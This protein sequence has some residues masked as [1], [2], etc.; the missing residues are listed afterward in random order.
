MS[1]HSGATV[2]PFRALHFDPRRVSFDAVIAPPF[3]IISPEQRAVLAARSP[4]NVVH[5]ILPDEGREQD[6]HRLI[7]RWRSDGVL[8]LDD[9]PC[10]YWVEQEYVDPEGVPRTRT[11][12][13]GLARLEPYDRRIV[14]PHERTRADPIANR[15]ELMRATRAQLS[16]IFAVYHDPQRR[17]EHALL[18]HR[19]DRAEI[20]VIDDD[21]TRHRLWRVAAGHEVVADA[22][23][24][25]TLLIADGHHRYET[26]LRYR[27]ETGAEGDAAAAWV[28]V[29]MANADDG[30]TIYPTHRLIA[31]VDAREEEA[32]PERLAAAGLEVRE[33]ADGAAA[34]ADGPV[35]AAFVVLR[36]GRAPLLAIG[37]APGVDADLVQETLLSA[38]LGLDPE[39]VA[40]TDRIA[41]VHR[42]DEAI[43][44]VTP[45]TIGVLVRAP[46]IAQVECSALAG[47]TMP[48]KSTYFFPKT[49][50]GFV[51]YTLDDC[52]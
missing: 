47:R 16:P 44:G 45:G 31:G 26:A 27:A 17:A 7:C 46:T 8:T 35:E 18:E 38:V 34:L 12:F 25:S 32:L 21:G 33:C 19:D 30:L 2:R 41:Y 40:A 22:L 1:D 6:V 15:L 9:A 14:L 37:T 20:D 51:F 49:I 42:A 48:Q 11:G 36:A 13:I 24:R 5:L 29:Y 39:A 23:A 10:F 43:A 50:D 52:P 4:H 28:L 3:D